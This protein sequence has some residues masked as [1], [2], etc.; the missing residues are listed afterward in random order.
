MVI[1][2]QSECGR[3]EKTFAQ[4]EPEAVVAELAEAGAESSDEDEETPEE[5]AESHQPS[6]GI[7][8]RQGS[9]DGRSQCMAPKRQRTQSA[10]RD[11]GKL[12]FRL[13]R[14]Q[15][16]RES[17]AISKIKGRREGEKQCGAPADRG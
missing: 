16:D 4:P 17:R 8:S 15:D 1:R 3:K 14:R 5:Q 6:A 7:T 11:I 12:Q 13:E 9:G 10:K 2:Y